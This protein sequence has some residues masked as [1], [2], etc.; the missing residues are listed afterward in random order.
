MSLV[1]DVGTL[2]LHLDQAGSEK[3]EGILDLN[4]LLLE[5]AARIHSPCFCGAMT[6]AQATFCLPPECPASRAGKIPSRIHSPATAP[7]MAKVMGGCVHRSLI[8]KHHHQAKRF[9][10]ISP[11]EQAIRDLHTL[12]LP[13]H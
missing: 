8:P 2:R 13:T 7:N 5:L 6:N 11:P 3:H 4:R 1:H 12:L 9:D 10:H